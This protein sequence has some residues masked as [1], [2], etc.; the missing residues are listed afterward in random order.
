MTTMSR[1]SDLNDAGSAGFERVVLITGAGSG[2]GAALARRI[3]AP[4]SALMLHAR[5]ADHDARER[6]A[7]V[8]ADCSA[9]GAR[10]ATVFATS[11][12]AGPRSMWS[13]RRW[14]ASA[15]SINSSPTRDTRSAKR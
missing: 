10:C 15:H 14:R 9:N 7:Q 8:A 1:V 5:G 6:L 3:A 4:R 12:N 2:I 11:P 13:I